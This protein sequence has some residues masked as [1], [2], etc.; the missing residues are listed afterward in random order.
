[1]LLLVMGELD[2]AQVAGLPGGVDV[3]GCETWE[4]RRG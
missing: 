2:R 4:F 1:M 3:H